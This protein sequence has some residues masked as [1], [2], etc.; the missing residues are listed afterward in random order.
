MHRRLTS[1][2]VKKVYACVFQ[3]VK[4]AIRTLHKHISLSKVHQFALMNEGLSLFFR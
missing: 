3:A 1:V 4:S 2:D